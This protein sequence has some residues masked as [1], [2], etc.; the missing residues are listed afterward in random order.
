ME[1]WW[2][3]WD[4]AAIFI[5]TVLAV[6]A[7]LVFVNSFTRDDRATMGTRNYAFWSGFIATALALGWAWWE[8]RGRLR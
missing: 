7:G 5:I 8:L 6:V 4:V 1:L 3:T 2:L